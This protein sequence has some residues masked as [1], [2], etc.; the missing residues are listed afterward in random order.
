MRF[1][2]ALG[3]FVECPSWHPSLDPSLF[4]AAAAP[5][6]AQHTA[7]DFGPGYLSAD[8][9]SISNLRIIYMSSSSS[10]SP[11]LNQEMAKQILDWWD[12]AYAIKKQQSP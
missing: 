1:S 9:L 10:A 8:L 6:C 12:A 7:Q 5:S 11:D 3:T 4:L 2:C